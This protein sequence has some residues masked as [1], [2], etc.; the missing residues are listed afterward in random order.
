MHLLLKR[1]GA[2]LIWMKN[3]LLMFIGVGLIIP[4]MPTFI[5]QLG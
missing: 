1:W 3:L 2:M 4:V 5:R